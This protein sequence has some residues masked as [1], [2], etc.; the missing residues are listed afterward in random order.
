[1]AAL[2]GDRQRTPG[3]RIRTTHHRW[4]CSDIF[5][6]SPIEEFGLFISS[7]ATRHLRQCQ[8]KHF[9]HDAGIC[10]H[11]LH[12]QG[13]HTL[14]NMACL[15]H[16]GPQWL[17]VRNPRPLAVLGAFHNGYRAYTTTER[18]LQDALYSQTEDPSSSAVLT[19]LKTAPHFAQTVTEKIVQRYSLGLRKGQVVKAGGMEPFLSHAV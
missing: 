11:S 5:R 10:G 1:V 15:Q 16:I 6:E 12:F 9:R 19:S 14:I 2:A 7:S 13:S 17:R 8:H 4:L 3:L 18:R